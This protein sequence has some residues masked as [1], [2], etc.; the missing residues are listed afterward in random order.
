MT[1]TIELVLVYSVMLSGSLLQL[2]S[3]LFERNWFQASTF[4]DCLISICSDPLTQ[5]TEPA[6]DNDTMCELMRCHF[7]ILKLF[8]I[9]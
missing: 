3:I 4:V 8:S 7:K 9:L 6:T 2:G 5:T 1:M